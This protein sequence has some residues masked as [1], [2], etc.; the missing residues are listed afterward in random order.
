MA[1]VGAVQVHVPDG[2]VG[3]TAVAVGVLDADQ[4]AIVRVGGNVN[5]PIAGNGAVSVR[6]AADH[7]SGNRGL[8]APSAVVAARSVDQQVGEVLDQC[9]ALEADVAAVGQRLPWDVEALR[10]GDPGEALLLG[11]S[12]RRE[13]RV[14]DRSPSQIDRL[15][16]VLVNP[17]LQLTA[18]FLRVRG[19]CGRRNVRS[20]DRRVVPVVRP[21][22]VV[23]RLGR[24]C[25]VGRLSPVAG[26]V[27]LGERG[28]G[29]H[30][31]GVAVGLLD[32]AS[33]VRVIVGFGADRTRA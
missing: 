20:G 11:L 27:A 25:E 6:S 33:G 31:I 24:V 15:G 10:D 8:R 4:R 2:H 14:V 1:R 9:P 32:P 16:E 17:L 13:A 3:R 12:R 21:E 26:G 22:A 18:G 29:L 30:L 7:R 28:T 5:A 23:D 19:R